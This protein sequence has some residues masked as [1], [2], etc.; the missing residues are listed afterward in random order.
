MRLKRSLRP[1]LGEPVILRCQPYKIPLT[2]LLLP[3][4]I[5]PVEFFRLWPSLPAIVE[6][7]GTYI[8]EGSGFKATAAQQYG[9]SPFSSGLKS[10]YSKPFHRVC[11]HIIRTVAGFQLCYAAKTWHGGFLGMMIFGASEVSRNVDLGDETTTM[12]YK[13]VVRASDAS[14]TKHIESDPQDWLDDLTDGGVEYM[15]E[16]EVKVAAAE[17]LRISMERIAL[18]KAAQPKKTPKTDDKSEDESEDEEDEDKKKKEGEEDGKPKGPS[19]LSKLKEAEHRALQAAVLLE[20]H[21]LCKDR[22]MKIG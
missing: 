3:H 4:K 22:N 17:R 2:E 12:M 6:Y 21:M 9:S 5:S 14:I 1:E 7:T 16:D 11:S 15:P 20:W 13:F 10:L 18:L 19:T 8:Y